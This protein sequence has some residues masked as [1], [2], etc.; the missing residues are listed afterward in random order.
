MV[1][2]PNVHD[3]R[4]TEAKNKFREG[5]RKVN[6]QDGF[7]VA[8]LHHAYLKSIGSG[9]SPVTLKINSHED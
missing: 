2:Q 1:Q 3:P 7:R 9:F 5:L 4:L 8:Q 6:R